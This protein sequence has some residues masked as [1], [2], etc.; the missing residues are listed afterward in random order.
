MLYYPPFACSG[1]SIYGNDPRGLGTTH[2]PESSHVTNACT[3]VADRAFIQWSITRRDR[4]DA[5]CSRSTRMRTVI[6]ILCVLLICPS[7]SGQSLRDA[8]R[9]G[10]VQA[11]K[12]L[13]DSGVDV[14]ETYDNKV[15]A[16][17][18][19]SEPSV[20][21]LLIS[22]GARLDGRSA[23]TRRSAIEKAAENYY[24]RE[25]EREKWKLIAEK[26][27]DG[28]AEYT[29]ETA[30]YLNDIP[31]VKEKM[32]SGGT[33]INSAGDAQSVPLRLA[34]ETGRFEICKLLLDHGADPDSFADGIGYPI[35]IDAVRHPEIVKLLIDRG[36]NLKRRITWLGGRSG[37]WIVGDEA[38][39]LHYAVSSG[40]L[41]S[42]QLLLEA[43]MDPSAADDKG[44]PPLHIAIIFERWERDNQR[45][46]TKFPAI[47]ELLL[48]HDASIRF[49]DKEGRT[50]IELARK[51]KSSDEIRYAL[52]KKQE[53]L[54]DELQLWRAK[55]K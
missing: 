4:G 47:V 27:R 49:E 6:A 30:I 34:A 36:A 42:V 10:D 32:Q 52:R 40:N 9:S 51:V 48:K 35:M 39:A 25:N 37:I 23:A 41:K 53:E 50:P 11:V 5:C 44:Q 7:V 18:A 38:T 19:A 13:L 26:L 15:T 12:K 43:G 1:R 46:A 55:N 2:T 24:L 3:G 16:I 28:G 20:V 14:N 21:D 31:F 29:I 8:V 33:W 17:F 54:S 22:R 45:D